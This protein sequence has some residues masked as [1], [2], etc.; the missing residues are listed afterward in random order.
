MRPFVR[1]YAGYIGTRFYVIKRVKSRK[2]C[3]STDMRDSRHVATDGVVQAVQVSR[4]TCFVSF[5]STLVIT[6]VT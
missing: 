1:R 3:H 2:G 4:L 6:N 5:V